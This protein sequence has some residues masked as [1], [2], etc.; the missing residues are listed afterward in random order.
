MDALSANEAKTHFGNMLLR[1]QSAPIQ[2]NKNGKPVAVVISAEEYESIQA[3]KLKMLQARAAQAK[4]DI[5]AGN[6]KDGESFFDELEA[7]HHD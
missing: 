3:L 4:A 6:L 5:T 1:V 7:G 2:I